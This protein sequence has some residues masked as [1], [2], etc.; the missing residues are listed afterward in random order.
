MM[1][2]IHSKL[3]VR[4]YASKYLFVD[5][6]TFV[7]LSSGLL[8]GL[9]IKKWYYAFALLLS[10]EVFENS[11]GL[12]CC[13]TTIDIIW[14]LIIGMTGWITTRYIIYKYKKYNEVKNGKEKRR[15]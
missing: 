11:V 6:W 10:W 15:S 8:L 1:D 14:D 13:E 7:H 3:G 12:W 9:F 4:I 2:Y 5:Y